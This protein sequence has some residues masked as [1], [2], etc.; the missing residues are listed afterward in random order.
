[1]TSVNFKKNIFIL[2]FLFSSSCTG[3]SVTSMLGNA[4]FS[5]KGLKTSLKDAY[6]FSKI[7]TKFTSL[8]LV[9]IAEIGVHVSLGRVLLIGNTSSS[10]ERLELVK[11]TWSIP[12]VIEVYNEI[13]IRESY[14]VLERLNDKFI[15]GKISAKLLL[16]PNILSNNYSL[17]VFK[18]D[19]FIIG[20]S[21]NIEE[22]NNLYVLLNEFTQ[23]KKIISFVILKKQTANINEKK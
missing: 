10:N 9:N 22:K 16:E 21:K 20:I 1:M 14:S 5:E 4:A 8:N 17:Q 23:I 6:T 7:K 11:A 19:L 15:E 3:S 18:K 2:F 13:K 12:G